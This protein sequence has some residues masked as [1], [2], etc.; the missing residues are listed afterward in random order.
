MSY[1]IGRETVI[2]DPRIKG[3]APWREQVFVSLQRNTAPTGSTFS[4]P[5]HQVVEIGTEVRI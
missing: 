3:M 5:S 1:Y 2:A 4:I